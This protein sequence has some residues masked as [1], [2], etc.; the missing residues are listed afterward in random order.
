[1]S[2][3]AL[4]LPW[5][6]GHGYGVGQVGRAA[7]QTLGFQVVAGALALPIAVLSPNG[8]RFVMNVIL[9]AAAWFIVAGIFVVL[10]LL[11]GEPVPAGLI[12]ARCLRRVIAGDPGSSR[13]RP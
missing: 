12:H 3:V 2:T 7:W 5:W 4:T 13:R 6:I 8:G 10:A 11:G 9:V 1:M